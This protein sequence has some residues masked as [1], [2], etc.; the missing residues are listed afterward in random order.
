[1]EDLSDE[2]LKGLD[3]V[4]SVDCTWHQAK[5]I[6]RDIPDES[7]FVI[8]NDYKTYFWRYQH[9]SDNLLAT[10]ESIYYFYKE[11]EREI[12]KRGIFEK[13]EIEEFGWNFDDFLFFYSLSLNMIVKRHQGGES[14]AVR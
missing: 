5:G 10:A 2:E 8:L 3:G 12:A 4:M 9:Y 13:S 1:M 14:W 7:T 6:I 11:Y